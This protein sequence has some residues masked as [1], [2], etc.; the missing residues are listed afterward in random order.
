MR[1]IKFRGRTFNGTIWAY[2]LI[3]MLRFDDG[4]LH[5]YI[6]EYKQNG[7]YTDY[8]VDPDTIGQFTGLYDKN[9]KEIYEGDVFRFGTLQGVITLHP[10]GY[11]CI[12]TG[13]LPVENYSYNSLGDMIEHLKIKCFDYEVIGNIYDTNTEDKE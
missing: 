5:R 2:G 7:G 6:R 11:W 13:E 1:T 3:E 12:H 10:D 8:E 9:G 4:S